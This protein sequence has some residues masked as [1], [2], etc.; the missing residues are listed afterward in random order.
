MIVGILGFVFGG[1][2][3]WYTGETVLP[4]PYPTPILI[5]CNLE[6]GPVGTPAS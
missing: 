5:V 2:F 4:Y 3:C 1:G 6:L